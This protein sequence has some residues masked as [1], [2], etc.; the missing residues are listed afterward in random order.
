M[1]SD[2]ELLTTL[3]K[4]TSCNDVCAA[5]SS[6]INVNISEVEEESSEGEEEEES[7]SDCEDDT[8]SDISVNCEG[9]VGTFLFQEMLC[10]R[11]CT[12]RVRTYPVGTLSLNM[13]GLLN[14]YYTL[15]IWSA[16]LHNVYLIE[17]ICPSEENIQSAQNFKKI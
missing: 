6:T 17:L 10:R 13:V 12:Q 11:L 3:G 16:K 14:R 1:Y 2:A 15:V 7:E 5:R 8:E 4:A 9:P